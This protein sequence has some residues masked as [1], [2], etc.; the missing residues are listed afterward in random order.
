MKF[1]RTFAAYASAAAIAVSAVGVNAFVSNNSQ[2]SAASLDSMN[3]ME[4]VNSMGAGYN[5]GNVL[6]AHDTNR[7]FTNPEEQMTSW[8]NSVPT[9]E[10]IQQ[11]HKQGF[12]TIRIPITWYKWIDD[13]GNVDE[14]WMTAVKQVVD[15]A[16]DDGMYVIINVVIPSKINRKQKELFKLL[17]ETELDDD[18]EFTKYNRKLKD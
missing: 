7:Q 16:I 12:D 11:I 13:K 3:A 2:V 5:L 14:K 15:W 1:K 8:G 18:S 10:T 4:L 6:D 9:K 17:S